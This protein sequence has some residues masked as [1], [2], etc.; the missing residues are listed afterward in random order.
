[1][2]NQGCGYAYNSGY[3]RQDWMYNNSTKNVDLT[4]YITSGTMGCVG[5]GVNETWLSSYGT[6]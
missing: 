3:F 5:C 6:G 4:R 1:M 2:Q